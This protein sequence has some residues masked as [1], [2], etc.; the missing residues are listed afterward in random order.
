MRF[1]RKISEK[2]RQKIQNRAQ[3]GGQA[4]KT[5]RQDVL[6]GRSRCVRSDSVLINDDAVAAVVALVDDGEGTT[7][8]GVAEGEEGVVHQ[9]H[10]EDGFLDAHGAEEETLG[11]DDLVSGFLV[12]VVFGDEVGVVG[13]L[14][15]FFA[16]ALFQPGV[17][18][19]QLLPD[20]A[21]SLGF[22]L[23]L[24]VAV[25]LADLFLSVSV[26]PVGDVH[27]LVGKGEFHMCQLLS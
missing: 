6:P 22:R 2:W 1:V 11:A 4:Q 23:G 9:V 3:T 24:E 18:L 12:D 20:R 17:I 27:F 26:D 13:N 21:G 5:A 10:L 8:V 25:Q 16:Q 7:L 15:G 19:T 14:E